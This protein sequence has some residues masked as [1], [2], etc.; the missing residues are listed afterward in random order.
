ENDGAEP[1]RYLEALY[2]LLDQLGVQ[3]KAGETVAGAGEH[4]RRAIDSRDVQPCLRQGRD[5]AASPARQLEHRSAEAARECHVHL[6]VGDI[7]VVLPVVQAG[8]RVEWVGTHRRSGGSTQPRVPNS[9]AST[10]NGYK[11][12]S[13]MAT[14]GASTP[15]DSTH[16]TGNTRAA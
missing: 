7:W 13:T 2:R 9:T 14:T 10:R 11:P 8:D 3:P 12:T 4:L 15:T 5:Q 1:A 16:S 6:D